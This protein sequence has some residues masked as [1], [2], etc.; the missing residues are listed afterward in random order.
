MRKIKKAGIYVI[1]IIVTFISIFP[2]YW[3]IA[4]A[5]NNSTDVLG[6][7]LTIGTNLMANFT[8]LTASQNL[9]RAFGNSMFYSVV[10]SLLSLLVCSI[11]G[12]GFEIYHDKAKDAL[13]SVLLLAMM[14]PFAATMIPLFKMF[15]G[16]HLQSTWIAYILPTI[17]TP[18]LI[19]LF[20]QSARSFPTEIIEAARIDGLSE[21]RI[22]TRIFFPTMRST[23]AAAMTVTFMNAWNSYLWPK[24]IMMSDTS[25]TMPM[26]VAN[27]SSGYS[28]DYGVLML[29][30][31]VCSLPTGIL[32]LVLQK[33]FANGIV[34]AVKG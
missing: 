3:M 27:L 19:M 33:S 4:A 11:A 8:K 9:G 21:L 6:G 25:Q 2:L 10:L 23:Y 20:R 34:G 29:G 32:F 26:L 24:V 22:F 17:S 18:F 13:M 14:V 7:K 5:T 1:L 15:T 30:V 12:Y 31:L 28:I 16:A